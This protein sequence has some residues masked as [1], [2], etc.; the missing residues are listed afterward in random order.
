MQKVN[1]VYETLAKLEEKTKKGIS[2]T[3]ISKVLN[4]DRANISRYLN[5]LYKEEKVEKIEGRPVLYRLK[6]I[7]KVQSKN[8]GAEN[9]VHEVIGSQL[10]LHAPLEQAKAAILYPP[11][12]LHT[13]IL[14]ET[15]VGKSMFAE[16]MYHFS[17]DVKVIGKDSP[18]IRF[19]CAD[20]ADNPQLVMSQ[21]FGVK[22]GAYTGA[23]KDKEGLLKKAH[24]GILFLDEVHRLSPQGQEML[25]TYID[26]GFFRPLGETEKVIHVDVQIIAATTEDPQSYLLKT[27]TRRIPMTITLPSL[28][29]REM[30]ERHHLIEFFIKE[31]SKR[32]GK[33]IYINKNSL[34]S[35]LLYDCPNNIGQLKSD[36]Q[37]AC[38]KAFVNYKSKEEGYILITQVDLPKHVKRGLMKIQE[39]RNEIDSIFKTKEEILRF[40]HKDDKANNMIQQHHEN[41][42]FYD[43]IDKK[44]RALKNTGMRDEEINQIIN[45]DIESHFQKYIGDLPKKIRDK[46]ISNI[47]DIEILDVV[48]EIL[49][50]A[51]KRLDKEFE[52]KIYLGLAL[53]LQGCIKRIRDGNKVYHPKLNLIR[54]G[55]PDEFLVAMEIAKIIDNKFNI[56]IPLD[57]IGYLTMFLASNPL[58]LDGEEKAKVAIL[59]IMHG[60]STASSMAD[61]ANTLVGA[62]HAIALDMP[63]SMKPQ[64]MYE[65]AKQHVI[66]IH[67]GRG[68]LLLVDMGSLTNF[69][70][71]IYEETG[72]IVKT[73]D[74][75][76][77]PIV[78]DACRK[79]ILG[80]ELHEI[81]TTCKEINFHNKPVARKR[82][83]DKNNIIITACFTGEGAS[84]RLKR[85]I[86]EKLHKKEGIEVVPLNILDRREFLCRIDQYRE[87]HKVL[88][89]V[90]T[91]N[92]HVNDIPFITAAEVLNSTG[93]GKIEKIIKEEETY[94]NVGKSLKEH[95]KVID[96]E[97]IIDEVRCVIDNIEKSL[98]I[99]VIDEVKIGII[100]HISFLVDKLLSGGSETVFHELEDYKS[101]FSRELILT[102]K[103]LKTLEDNC[104][105]EIGENEL[106]YIC[107]MFLLNSEVE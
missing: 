20:Y 48:D 14:G 26:K 66:K 25:F 83:I 17:K 7:K 3:E 43:I 71:L 74:M 64:A 44:L 40:H 99:Q 70:D 22:K 52:E 34:I 92:I 81:Y 41:E 47:V 80:R 59:V 77:T 78:I 45:I 65:V 72:I 58:E 102:K 12:G 42:D 87:K 16:L 29:D 93:I 90:G 4:A 38:A 8:I 11:R 94:L 106:A 100:L 35:L 49:N 86:E 89:I 62:E 36:I 6:K 1:Q 60:N 10:S 51:K 5:Q 107:K 69:G 57:E 19:N 56:E 97:K 30:V 98:K 73:I 79:A 82:S 101:Q 63:L 55:Y 13:L 28:R 75:V 91:I 23:E 88:A 68:V 95:M 76:S 103:C 27:F 105:I 24:G 15:G 46:E 31:E 67:K 50:L 2:A 18:F 37:L 96:G 84:E 39:H 85:I 53:H 21:I 33:S 54:I 32:I 61:V 9:S 104:N